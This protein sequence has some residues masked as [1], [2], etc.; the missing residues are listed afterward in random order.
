MNPP[1]IEL[2]CHESDPGLYG[3]PWQAMQTRYF[4]GSPFVCLPGV[5]R[6]MNDLEVGHYDLRPTAG[7]AARKK[8]LAKFKAAVAETRALSP[9]GT[10][11]CSYNVPCNWDG[12]WADRT[13]AAQQA[14][15]DHACMVVETIGVDELAIQA[16][17]AYPSETPE[18]SVPLEFWETRNI[19]ARFDLGKRVS[20]KTGKPLGVVCLHHQK[21]VFGGVHIGRVLTAFERSPLFKMI[22]AERP[23]WVYSWH[24]DHYWSE[25]C[26]ISDQHAAATG[27]TKDRDILRKDWRND[28]WG[29]ATPDW[30]R[31]E[32]VV[33]RMREH[34]LD[35]ANA[36]QDCL[37]SPSEVA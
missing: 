5:R 16:Y 13:D 15:V 11:I 7:S 19:A 1:T 12:N 21:S 14:V 24:A 32:F 10:L 37:D 8:A 27:Q 20:S 33:R 26:C 3:A 35:W 31:K 23:A 25:V 22:R 30:S 28:V 18:Q 34:R 4:N 17:D 2:C 36:L 6:V 29:L 9:E